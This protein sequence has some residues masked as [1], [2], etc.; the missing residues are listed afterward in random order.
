MDDD[1]VP[2]SPPPG[3]EGGWVGACVHTSVHAALHAHH[4]TPITHP[5]TPTHAHTRPPPTM[6]RRLVNNPA[7]KEEAHALRSVEEG[8]PLL[9]L[10]A[11]LHAL[12]LEE[13]MG[14]GS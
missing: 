8:H 4:C 2:S 14:S 13:G 7:Q 1:A 5:R 10:A 3:E 9:G 11:S 6:A 12:G